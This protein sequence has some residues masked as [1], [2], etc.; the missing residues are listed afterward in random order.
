MHSKNQCKNCNS[1]YRKH[2]A[3]G[4]CIKCYNYVRKMAI[5]MKWDI[6]NPI[7][8]KTYPRVLM[9]REPKQFERVKIGCVRQLQER[10]NWLREKEELKGQADGLDLELV[11]NRI[12]QKSGVRNK[13]MFNGYTD[14]FNNRF[15]KNQ[16]NLLYEFLNKIEQDIPWKINWYKVFSGG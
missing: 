7:T 13:S 10:L 3:K 9:G 1:I 11:F 15:E 4:Y 12:A 8:L 2:K 5:A 16:K 6:N 14:V